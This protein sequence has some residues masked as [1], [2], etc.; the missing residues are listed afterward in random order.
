MRLAIHILLWIRSS[1]R[2]SRSIL[3]N[4]FPLSIR[5][6][7]HFTK[8]TTKNLRRASTRSYRNGAPPCCHFMGNTSLHIT[9]HGHTSLTALVGTSIFFLSRSLEFRLHRHTSPKSLLK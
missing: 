3:P 8:R 1:R 6:T 5:Q 9:I 2:R 4:P 7:P